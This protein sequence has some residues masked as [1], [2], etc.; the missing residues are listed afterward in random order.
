[1][2]EDDDDLEDDDGVV[3]DDADRQRE[4]EQRQRVEGQ[5]ERPH[6]PKR[7][8]DRSRDGKP[9]DDRRSNAPEKDEDHQRREQCADGQVL[10]YPIDAAPRRQRV[11]ADDLE[12]ISRWE[13]T[14]N[15]AQPC[16]YRIDGGDRVFARLLADG[17]DHGGLATQH[18]G[19]LG[20]LMTVFDARHVGQS[21]TPRTRP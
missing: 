2:N 9:G 12:R 21:A 8:D 17:E 1:M 15:L 7:P 11:V 10:L 18:R 19:A 14:L 20:V 3:D 5:T 16:A 4:R 6:G 13:S